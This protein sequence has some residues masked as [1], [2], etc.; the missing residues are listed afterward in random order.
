MANDYMDGGRDVH[1]YS[2]EE[3]QRFA[4]RFARDLLP[5]TVLAL[6][7]DLG[8]GKTCFVQGLAEGL[9]VEG[10]VSSPSYII[11]NEY[12]GKM[13]LYHVDFYRLASVDEVLEL[14][15]TE[16]LECKGVVAVEW[17][18]LAETLL[19]AGAIH[20][21]FECGEVP[22]MRSIRVEREGATC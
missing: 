17:P 6:H 4:R 15:F 1:T 16:I 14:G 2:A 10:I 12:R 3:T 13:P 5:G 21:Y 19:P 9:G 7:G 20:L 11:I 8:V 22:D 18:E